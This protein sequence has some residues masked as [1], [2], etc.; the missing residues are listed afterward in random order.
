MRISTAGETLLARFDVVLAFGLRQNFARRRAGGRFEPSRAVVSRDRPLETWR[1]RRRARPAPFRCLTRIAGQ[2]VAMDGF[3][4]RIHGR[5]VMPMPDQIP[6][7]ARPSALVRPAD[8]NAS[9]TT[10]V[11]LALFVVIVSGLYLA[12]EVIIP[13]TLAV[14]LAFVL[15]PLVKLLRRLGLGGFLRPCW[16]HF[17]RSRWCSGSL[18]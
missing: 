15:A 6:P 8:N 1:G 14:L 7:A 9:L 4:N 12:R 10:L 18:G 17:S 5:R 2:I 16:P 13:I 11:N 3:S